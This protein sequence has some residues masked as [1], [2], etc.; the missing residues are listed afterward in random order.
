[1]KKHLLNAPKQSEM[2][3]SLLAEMVLDQALR[4]FRKGQLQ[5]EIDLALQDGNKEQFLRLSKELNL[6]LQEAI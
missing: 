4:N 2:V 6:I 5:K 1:M 3:D